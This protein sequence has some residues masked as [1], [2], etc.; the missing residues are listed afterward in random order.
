MS[1]VSLDILVPIFYIGYIAYAQQRGQR[2]N[3]VSVSGMG[4]GE[5]GDVGGMAG[6]FAEAFWLAKGEVRRVWISYPLTGVFLMFMGFFVVPSVS[7]VF[8]FDGPGAAG[9]RMEGFYNAFFSDCLFVVVCAFLAATVVSGEG[10]P[11]RRSASY[12]GLVI[13]RHLAVPAGS[14][15]G[16][17]ALCML[18]ALVLNVPAVFLPAFLLSDLGGLGVSY[19]WFCGIWVGYGLLASGLLLL[20]EL[21]VDGRARALICFGGAAGVVLVLALLE[22]TVD[23]RLAQS[24]VELGQAHGA[25]VAVLSIVAGSVAFVLMAWVTAWRLQKRNL[26]ESPAA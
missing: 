25:L 7:G 19:L 21:T 6:V 9:E 12:S 2:S 13:L 22:W 15:V 11:A 4:T 23:L 17:R 24:S 10:A 20:L 1:L 8:E 26:P 3:G 18:L 5:R 14:V 16:S